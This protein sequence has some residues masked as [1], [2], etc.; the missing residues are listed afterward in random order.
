[1]GDGVAECL[2]LAIGGLG[3]CLGGGQRPVLSGKLSVIRLELAFRAA[4]FQR[5]LLGFSELQPARVLNEDK[6]DRSKKVRRHVEFAGPP[7]LRMVALGLDPQVE[8]PSRET[9]NSV[10]SGKLFRL[11]C[12]GHG[13][14]DFRTEK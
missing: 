13:A 11:S 6:V 14:D 1:M 10:G 3:R 12:P 5:G 7:W 4:G 9:E 8:G 2:E